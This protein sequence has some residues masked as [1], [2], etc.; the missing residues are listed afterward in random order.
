[1][2]QVADVPPHSNVF[3][4]KIQ[5]KEWNDLPAAACRLELTEGQRRQRLWKLLTFDLIA[6]GLIDLC[7]MIFYFILTKIHKS[8]RLSRSHLLLKGDQINLRNVISSFAT[9]QCSKPSNLSTAP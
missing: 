8:K 1:M 7:L 9:P 5:L 4:L 6:F 3:T 2:C